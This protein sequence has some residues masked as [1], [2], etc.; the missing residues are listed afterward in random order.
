MAFLLFYICFDKSYVSLFHLAIPVLMPFYWMCTENVDL[1]DDVC[2]IACGRKEA[3]LV[4]IF[5]LT[6]LQVPRKLCDYG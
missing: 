1:Y 5:S 4:G 3:A 6:L 2:L